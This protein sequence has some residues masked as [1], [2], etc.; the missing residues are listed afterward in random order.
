M[1]DRP[2]SEEEAQQMYEA[3]G[4]GSWKIDSYRGT[5]CALETLILNEFPRRI[6]RQLRRR[7]N[8]P[9]RPDPHV[10][11][12]AATA[13]ADLKRGVAGIA[14]LLELA[15]ALQ[16][17]AP[18]LPTSLAGALLAGPLH[19]LVAALVIK[20]E[21]PVVPGPSSPHHDAAAVLLRRI[22]V[23][24]RTLKARQHAELRAF[25]R[26]TRKEFHALHYGEPTAK[27]L[28]LLCAARGIEPITDGMTKARKRWDQRLERWRPEMDA[29]QPEWRSRAKAWGALGVAA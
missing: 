8:A 1:T 2:I 3:L 13:F 12:W 22:D 17:V 5:Y 26:A 20:G 23:R 25:F 24:Y 6:H 7:E 21:V 9:T 11:A 19:D 27:V 15:T 29:E 14:Q 10:P 18:E 4:F 28:A 16:A